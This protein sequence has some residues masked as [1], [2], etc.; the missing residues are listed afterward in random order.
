MDGQVVGMNTAVV[1]DAQNIGFAVSA[2]T[3]VQAISDLTA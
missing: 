1:S 2:S 3:I